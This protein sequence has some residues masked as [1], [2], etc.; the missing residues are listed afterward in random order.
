M[1][2]DELLSEINE[3]S[4]KLDALFG[5]VKL[6]NKF[7]IEELNA[8][9]GL[10]KWV[11]FTIAGI[12]ALLLAL[13]VF[14][15]LNNRVDAGQLSFATAVEFTAAV[16]IVV[17]GSIYLM[18]NHKFSD[19]LIFL[20]HS[21]AEGRY[22]VRLKQLVAIQ[23]EIDELLPEIEKKSLELPA[24]IM[25]VPNVERIQA[26]I[27]REQA[28]SIHD[29]VLIL[30][31]E[32]KNANSYY[33]NDNFSFE[34]E[35]EYSKGLDLKHTNEIEKTLKVLEAVNPLQEPKQS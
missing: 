4:S 27:K 35:R 17:T 26:F 29:A 21:I 22:H 14:A 3:L 13:L 6:R 5:K 1:N 15:I 24:E 25:T 30:Q 8:E 32:M 18:L 19:L 33:D 34:R 7:F 23:E 11:V 31:N 16:A 12:P 2:V 28:Y 9:K 10:V 20:I